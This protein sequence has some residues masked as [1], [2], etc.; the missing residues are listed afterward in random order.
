MRPLLVLVVLAGTASAQATRYPRQPL[1]PKPAVRPPPSIGL[2]EALSIDGLRGPIR[3]EQEQ[4]LK[5]LVANTPDSEVEE[6]SDYY[7]RLG[8][9]YAKLHRMWRLRAVEAELH[10]APER[11]AFA[12]KAKDYL[13][14]AVQT[15][16]LLTDRDAF[17]TYPKLDVA[18]FD[19]AY[20][21]ESGRYMKEARAVF[22]KLIKN[23]PMSKYVPEA[24]VAFADYYFDANQPADAERFYRKVLEFP[25]SSVEGYARYKLAW[26]LLE[27]NRERDALEMFANVARM[28]TDAS[29][30]PVIAA[31]RQDLTSATRELA[32]ADHAAWAATRDT[33]RLAKAEALYTVYLDASPGDHGDVAYYFAELLWS[34]ADVEPDARQRST[35]WQRAAE[36]F[37]AA[38]STD[39]RRRHDIA[40]AAVL[41]WKNAL[42]LDARPEIAA[43][44][45]DLVAASRSKLA[46][47]AIPARD[48]EIIDACAAFIAVA[49]AG[50]P[51]VAST[52]LVEALLYRR[53][54]HA[55]QAI[56]VLADLVAHHRTD[57][58][59]EV[60]ANLMLEQLL[61]TRRFDDALLLVDQLAAD[62]AF[63]ANKSALQHNIQ[64][65]RSRSLR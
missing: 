60:S 22:D 34:H 63:V 16:K 44:P 8:E 15:F 29:Q 41:A 12:M 3:E 32:F 20:T 17:R 30:Q 37:H 6:K 4:I 5:Q 36:A 45:I 2:D 24:Y 1:V 9:L 33:D 64:L 31:A 55:D 13:I 43:G 23:Y 65:L 54:D 39:P 49:T 18:L 56:A 21:L 42:D 57:D 26:T 28:P 46:V 35:R 10:Q 61:R 40:L 38:E 19:Y 7:F 47:R 58:T 11:Q 50:E 59:A 51:D 62:T 14:K 53:S 25:K 27:T 48:Q 52:K